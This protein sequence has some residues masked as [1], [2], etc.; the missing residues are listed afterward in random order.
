[1]GRA[2]ATAW[3]VKKAKK[4]QQHTFQPGHPRQYYCV[5]NA[6][7]FGERTG[8]GVFHVE[9]AD[10]VGLGG[11]YSINLGMEEIS[12]RFCTVFSLGKRTCTVLKIR[13]RRRINM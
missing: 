1:M 12:S 5:S 9:M 3:A 4:N 7:S 13:A 10:S 2:R 11:R 8:S 6:L